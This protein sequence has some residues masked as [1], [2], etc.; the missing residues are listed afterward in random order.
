MINQGVRH[1]QYQ[2]LGCENPFFKYV[3]DGD[4]DV[5]YDG[6]DDYDDDDVRIRRA[7]SNNEVD[8][9]SSETNSL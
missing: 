1:S 5:D 9:T 3:K 7:L 2:T 8:T 6:N 4:D